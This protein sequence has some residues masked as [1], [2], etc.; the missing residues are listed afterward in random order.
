[1]AGARTL[2]AW[3]TSVAAAW[4][5]VALHRLSDLPQ[6]MPVGERL[7]M[8]VAVELGGLAPQDVNVEA[9]MTRTLPAAPS[10]R[11]LYSSYNAAP[12]VGRESLRATGETVA[13]GHVFALDALPPWSGQLSLKIRAVPKHELLSH[14]HELG[15]MKWI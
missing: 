5:K 12:A 15:L 4:P 13:Q 1:G 10:D 2:A 9:V 3:K 6:R 7:R 8:R 11:P 14:P